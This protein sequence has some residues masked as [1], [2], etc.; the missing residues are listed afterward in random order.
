[1][2]AAARRIR[3][4]IVT[5][6]IVERRIAENMVDAL[7]AEAGLGENCGRRGGV[8]T[9]DAD[10]V[11]KAVAAYILLRELGQARIDLDQA[12]G[13]ARNARCERKSRCTDAGSKLHGALTGPGTHRGSE[14]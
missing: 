1:M 2:R 10:A 4:R 6:R 12:Y 8:K 3:R 14:Q 7:C 11:G 5:H 13:E 9:V